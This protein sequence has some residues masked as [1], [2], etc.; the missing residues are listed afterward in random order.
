MIHIPSNARWNQNAIT[1]A[2]GHGYGEVFHQLN[3]PWGL[4]LDDRD[5][6]LFI[7]D[8]ANHR[9][10]AWKQGENTG[11]L[12]VGGHEQ[13][14]RLNQLAVPTDVMLDKEND[15]L[16][17][18]EDG[19]VMEWS[20]RSSTTQGHTCIDNSSCCGVAMDKEGHLYVTN[21]AK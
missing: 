5:D 6:T 20:L 21:Q 17:I 10:V 16:I 8:Y 14:N 18:C 12:I 1:I 4:C 3:S 13:I 11:R 9:I 19:C 15:T 7:A 2:G